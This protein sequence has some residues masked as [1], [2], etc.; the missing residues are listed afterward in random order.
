MPEAADA[1]K[2]ESFIDSL[3][4]ELDRARDTL[5]V[6]GLTRRLTYAV[7]DVSLDLHVFPRY[8]RGDLRF[9]VA[10]PGEAGASR[11]AFQLGSITD[12]QIVETANEPLSSE[13]VSIE[14]VEDIEPEVRRELRRIGVASGRD[15]ERLRARNVDIGAVVG[16]G[17][18][19]AAR[20][21]YASLA[22]RIRRARRGA[23]RVGSMSL[24][25]A[26]EGRMRLT[27]TGEGLASMPSEEA[28]EGDY[29]VA[30][31]NGA[32][33][34]VVGCE[35]RSLTIEFPSEALRPGANALAVA[36]DPFALLTLT[37]A[38]GGGSR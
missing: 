6:K 30:A 20:I 24:S 15:L 27:L 32:E 4:V 17:S 18:D 36:L 26:E 10:R 14:E 2:L 37:L 38:R 1:W 7:K 13:D 22:D 8:E 31:L 35:A 9:A 33:A 3:V 12:R 34:K 28:G 25:P 11:V 16:R 5:S 19:G 29:P 23:P 21:D